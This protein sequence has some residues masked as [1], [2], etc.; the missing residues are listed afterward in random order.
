MQLSPKSAIKMGLVKGK[1]G[2]DLNPEEYEGKGSIDLDVRS[3]FYKND[4]GK[5]FECD[6]YYL[7]PQEMACL[8]SEQVINVKPG[9]VA[10]VFLKNRLS[11]QGL[12]AFN[13]GIIDSGF[14]GP[15]STSVTNFS[16]E[17]IPLGRE[18]PASERYFFRVVFHEIG[19]DSDDLLKCDER[20]YPYHTYAANQKKNFRHLPKSFLDRE[21]LQKTVRDEVNSTSLSRAALYAAIFAL[22]ATFFTVVIPPLAADARNYFYHDF[23]SKLEKVQTELKE[24]RTELEELKKAKSNN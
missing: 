15:I 1:N 13:T 19:F 2:C 5:I 22:G 24:V 3:I 20:N 16:Q 7:E 4:K 18:L 10:Y 9:Y 8:T 6:R 14:S 11:Q 12:L 21:K 17:H 23:D